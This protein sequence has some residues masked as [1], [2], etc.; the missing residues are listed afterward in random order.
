LL[1]SEI[2]I[3]D[4]IIRPLN[5]KEIINVLNVL[6][7]F[8]FNFQK[9]Q[10]LQFIENEIKKLKKQLKDELQYKPNLGIHYDQANRDYKKFLKK[11]QK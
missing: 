8:L 1:G 6:D 4:V 9:K 7:Y 2:I 3:N 10:K 11:I 5:Q